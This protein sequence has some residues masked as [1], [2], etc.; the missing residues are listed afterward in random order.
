LKSEIAAAE[1]VITGETPAVVT[2]NVELDAQT[3]HTQH[4]LHMN[5]ISHVPL[6][7]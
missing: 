2:R 1:N 3:L 6:A 5:K 4:T 7:V